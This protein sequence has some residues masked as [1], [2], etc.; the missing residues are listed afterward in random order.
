MRSGVLLFSIGLA[1]KVLLAD[2]LAFR[3]N[4]LLD[5][6]GSLGLHAAAGFVERARKQLWDL[7]LVS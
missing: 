6:P 4:P 7:E 2:G 1:K 5:N 3:A